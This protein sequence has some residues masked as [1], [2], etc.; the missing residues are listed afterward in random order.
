MLAGLSLTFTTMADNSTV[1]AAD[2]K[3]HVAQVLEQDAQVMSNT[4]LADLTSGQPAA[5]QAEIL[6]INTEARPLAL[7]IALT[8][9]ILAGLTGLLISLRMRRQ[10]DPTGAPSPDAMGLG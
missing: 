2:E 8:I 3:A 1:L 7:Q 10:P 6:R 4:Q 5:T 9:P